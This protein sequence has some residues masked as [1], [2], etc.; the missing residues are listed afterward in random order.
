MDI[1]EQRGSLVRRMAWLCV[2]LSLAVVSLSAYLRLY[3]ADVGC[4][5]WPQ[6][7]EATAAVPSPAAAASAAV[8]AARLAHRVVASVVLVLV[9]VLV[10]ACAGQA[11]LRRQRRYALALLGLALGLAALGAVARGST[12]APVAIANL[13]GGLAMLG[14]SSALAALP[15]GVRAEDRAALAPLD[16]GSRKAAALRWV[17]ACGLVMQAALGAMLSVSHQ[18]MQ[19]V[20]APLWQ[21]HAGWAVLLF[22]GMVALWG[23]ARGRDGTPRTR[24]LGVMLAVTLAQ[25]AGG[26]VMLGLGVPLLAAWAHNLGAAVLVAAVPWLFEP[27]TR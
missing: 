21:L 18:I 23:W 17:V 4:T 1:S 8:A 11:D 14:A 26:G 2:V 16:A 7:F 20:G 9:V 3:K 10:W 25:A 24:V 15:L 13:L 6:C 12:A 5:P 22:A 27:A 19:G